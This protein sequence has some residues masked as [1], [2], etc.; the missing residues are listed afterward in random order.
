[1]D[2]S[3]FD[4]ESGREV[5]MPSPYDEMS[6]RASPAYVGGPA[7]ARRLRDLLRSTLEAAGFRVNRGEWWHFDHRDCP[8]YDVLDLSFEALDAAAKAP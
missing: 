3:L 2:V 7:E 1:V 4:L 5:V 8:A 6:A